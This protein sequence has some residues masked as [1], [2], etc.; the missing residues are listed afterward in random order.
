MIKLNNNIT[1][2]VEFGHGD[3]GIYP[4]MQDKNGVIGFKNQISREIGSRAAEKDEGEMDITDFPTV[5]KFTDVRSVDVLIDVL[6]TVKK[7]M[8]I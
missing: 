4:D 7:E 8:E 5:F 2:I 6:E 3:I 1:T